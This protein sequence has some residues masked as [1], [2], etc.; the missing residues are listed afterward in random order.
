MES[1]IGR[2]AVAFA[3]LD[4]VNV[5]DVLAA[6]VGRIE[7]QPQHMR[8]ACQAH[9]GLAHR[10]VGCPSAGV[11]KRQRAGLVRAVDLDVEFP[12]AVAGGDTCVDA[13]T[14]GAAHVDRVF[15]P[16]T[17]LNMPDVEAIASAGID[18]HAFAGAVIPALICR[19]RIVIRDAL[20][21]FVE[22]LGFDRPGHADGRA[23]KGR[24]GK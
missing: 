11:G 13:I 19:G 9:A 20:A 18:V 8:P 4:E 14:A 6:L 1:I 10:L 22:V 5:T 12:A 7:L 15:Q 24:L 17:R 23:G 3:E 2:A 16:L 21:A